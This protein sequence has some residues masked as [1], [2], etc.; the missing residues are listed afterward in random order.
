MMNKPNKELYEK[1]QKEALAVLE[2]VKQDYANIN[3]QLEAL[4]NNPVVRDYLETKIRWNRV[5]EDL[6][7]LER[8]LG[9]W[10]Y[11]ISQFEDKN[12]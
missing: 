3:A 12:S 4:E 8:R 9:T 6:R 11:C 1:L 2:V 5:A 7:V 10:T